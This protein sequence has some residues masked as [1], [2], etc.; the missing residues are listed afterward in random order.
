M[1]IDLGLVAIITYCL[2]LKTVSYNLLCGKSNTDVQRSKRVS[3]TH[4]NIVA[5]VF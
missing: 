2:S 5:A 1:I 3:E 4:F